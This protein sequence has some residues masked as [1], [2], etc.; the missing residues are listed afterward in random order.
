MWVYSKSETATKKAFTQLHPFTLQI[1]LFQS[2]DKKKSSSGAEKKKRNVVQSSNVKT[3]LFPYSTI[4]LKTF[5]KL[6]L[7]SD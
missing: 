1:L 6:Y 7:T 3:Q 2:S 5:L 4:Y